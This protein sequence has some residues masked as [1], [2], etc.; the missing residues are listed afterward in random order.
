MNTEV[1]VEE[2]EE[3]RDSLIAMEQ[4][5]EDSGWDGPPWIVVAMPADAE[6]P[7]AGVVI[8]PSMPNVPPFKFLELLA[9]DELPLNP[10][11][12]Y[13]AVAPVELMGFGVV[14]EAWG[15]NGEGLS[16]EEWSKLVDRAHAEGIVNMTDVRVEQRI[17][18]L[19]LQDGSY[20]QGYRYRG[21]EFV[22]KHSTEIDKDRETGEE[23]HE[24]VSI[25]LNE[26]LTRILQV[27]KKHREQLRA[28]YE[29]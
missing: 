4:T 3:I 18:S 25:N 17:L 23:D 7:E 1:T 14:S 28:G 5:L 29:S 19:V 21:S 2:R 9:K 24:G 26:T 15:I 22:L 8:L 10:L 20:F 16:K 12:M 13:A 6:D 27:G 11:G